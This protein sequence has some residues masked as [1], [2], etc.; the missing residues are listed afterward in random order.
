MGGVNFTRNRAW[1]HTAIWDEYGQRHQYVMILPAMTFMIPYYWHNCFASRDIELNFASKMYEV[2]YHHKRARLT[3]NL[4][5]EHFETH[6]EQAQ[7]ILDDVTNKG[8]E[9]TFKDILDQPLYEPFPKEKHFT[10]QDIND[11]WKAEFNQ[12]QEI[13]KMVRQTIKDFNYPYV[14]R[15]RLLRDYPL[16]DPTK[17]YKYHGTRLPHSLSYQAIDHYVPKP[18]LG[19]SDLEAK[20]IKVKGAEAAAEDEE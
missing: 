10:A 7:D 1:W 12:D 19:L 20:T 15:L 4:I 14:T 8:F 2:E 18:E 11:E 17:P 5:M 3:H 6:V 16:R 9:V 13:D